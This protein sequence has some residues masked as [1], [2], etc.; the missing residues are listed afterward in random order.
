MQTIKELK[1]TIEHVIEDINQVF[2][3]AHTKVDFDAVASSVAMSLIIKKLE[4]PVYII[5][6]EDSTTI[7]PGSKKMI[8]EISNCVSII[9]MNKFKRLKSEKD[10]LI[11]V[12]TNKDYKVC[13]KDF[14]NDF[15]NIL[16]IDH[17]HEDEHTIK[18][19]YIFNKPDGVSSA[20]EVL[21]DLLC[22]FKVKYSPTVANFLLAGIYVDTKTL[23]KKNTFK[24]TINAVSKLLSRGGDISKA[25]AYFIEDFNSDN[26]VNNLVSRATFMGYRVGVSLAEETERYRSEEL[27]KAADSLLR[28][29]ADATFATGYIDDNIVSIKARSNGR[30]D[31]GSIM[32]ELGGGGNTYSAATEL[33][34]EN[35]N[36]A[37][38]KLMKI[39]KPKFYKE[40]TN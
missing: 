31:V 36:A 4:K 20:S 7:E 3:V 29:D 23:T 38:E 16:V 34:D 12:D 28:Y 17:H 30:I 26:K 15:K 35:I 5:L 11:V 21:T 8:D 39:L 25:N 40:E 13:C 33:P 1:T 32:S 2:I 18:T 22:M 19:D 14:L 27:S 24:S 37:E 10:L 6:E 9:D